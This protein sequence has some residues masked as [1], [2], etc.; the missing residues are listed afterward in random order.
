VTEVDGHLDVLVNVVGG[1]FK[2]PFADTRPRGWDALIRANF[3]WLL[4]STHL[5]IPLMRRTGSGGSIINV[6]SIEAHRA[7]PTFAVYAAMK[8]AVTSFARTLAVELGPDRIRVNTIAPD[9]VPTER[10]LARPPE[11]RVAS[12]WGDDPGGVLATG[13]GIPMGRRGTYGDIGGSALVLASDLSSY[14]TGCSLHPDGGVTASSGWFNWPE[15]G[16]LNFPP[17]EVAD[18]LLD[19]PATRDE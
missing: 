12:G 18:R 13:I 15:S 4:H 14:I 6:T 5:A 10:M 11:E 19:R 3:T 16:F 2:Q 17:P 7:A 1:T 9:R 8:A